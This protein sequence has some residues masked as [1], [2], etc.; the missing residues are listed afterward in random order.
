MFWFVFK[1]NFYL[2]IVLMFVVVLMVLF[3]VVMI[4][5]GV[6]GVGF[7]CV[8]FLFFNF[9]GGIV[10]ILLWMNVY[11]LYGGLINV[12]F[13]KFGGWMGSDWL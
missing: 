11:D 5:C 7:F 3:F 8:V 9:F 1:N 6:W 13:V 12:V 10:V 2:M 4:Y